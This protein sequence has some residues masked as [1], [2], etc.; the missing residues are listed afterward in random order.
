[1]ENTL[2]RNAFVTKWVIDTAKEKYPQDIALVISHSTLRMHTEEKVMSYFVPATKRGEELACTFILEGVGYDIWSIPWERLERFAELKEYNI[3]CLADA[4]IL[5]ARTDQDAERFLAL[6]KRLQSNLADPK[7]MRS[8][9]L[10]SYAQAKSLYTD[11]LFAA[12]C[13]AKMCAGYILDYLARAIA[14]TNMRYFKASQTNQ[15]QELADM[16]DVPEGFGDLY[17]SILREKSVQQQK[18]LCFRLIRMVEGFLLKASPDSD[19]ARDK[20]PEHNFQDLAD[21]YAELSYT[22]LRLRYYADRGDA[23]KVYM[24]GILL[25]NELN[26]VCG[27]FGLEKVDL[28]S[29]YDWEDLPAFVARADALEVKMRESILRGGGIIREYAHKAEFLQK[30]VSL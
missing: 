2:E 9:A 30:G 15:L 14:F 11:M 26:Q 25:Q 5:Y 29:A 6:Q 22:W 27:D 1:M 13:D 21:W 3:T 7:K 28:M 24:W 17:L 10:E 18:S 16:G 23:V 19:A 4:D 8:L 20:C 12:D